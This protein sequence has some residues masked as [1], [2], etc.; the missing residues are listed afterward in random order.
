M[1]VEGHRAAAQ[2]IE[3]SLAKCAPDDYEMRIEAAMLAGTHWVNA[4]LHSA[5][6][7]ASANDVMHTYLLTINEYRKYCVADASLMNALSEIEDL[8]APF[9]RGDREGGQAA[10]E[11]ALALLALLR[12]GAE[13]S[14]REVVARH[15]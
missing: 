1:N 7:T 8:R 11:L 4:A 5:R 2:R 14:H 12:A 9:V 13:W 10:A 3:R 6:V 15:S